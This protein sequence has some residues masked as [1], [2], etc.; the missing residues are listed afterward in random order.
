MVLA[1]LSLLMG[2]GW[3]FWQLARL[4]YVSEEAPVQLR[5][6]ALSMVGGLNRIGNFVG[7]VLGGGLA[8]AFGLEAAFVVQA[9]AG[10]AAAAMMFIVARD[11]AGSEAMESHGLTGRLKDTLVE[12]RSIFVATGLP[13]FSLGL[14]R[15]GRE[16]F[17]PLW[18][19][20]I[21]LDVAAIGAVTS[22]SFF[23]DAAVFYPVGYVMDRWGRK[24]AAVPCLSTLA[25]GFLIL[26]LTTDVYGFLAVAVV[27]G[28]GNGFGSGI[29]MTLG[30]DFAPDLGRGEFLGLWR[31]M[32]DIGQLGGPIV[33]SA[34]TGVGSLALASAASGA[35]GVAGAIVMVICV[36]ETLHRHAPVVETVAEPAARVT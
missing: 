26:P 12:N 13:I 5:G 24:W 23:A 36:Q 1:G 32:S 29:V 22:I 20:S 33:I 7:P 8:S 17:L 11:S 2:G 16:V 10:I 6:R 34:L 19:D 28:V 31:L 21:G 18:G 15:R 25:L 27:T 35:I 14:L 30:A 9:V 4:A 3:A